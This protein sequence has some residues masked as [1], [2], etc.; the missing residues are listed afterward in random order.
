ML[1]V[2]FAFTNLPCLFLC[3][4]LERFK[5]D[6]GNAAISSQFTVFNDGSHTGPQEEEMK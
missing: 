3:E 6:V 2:G 4:N 5:N 1:S